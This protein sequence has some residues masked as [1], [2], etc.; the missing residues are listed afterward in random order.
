MITLRLLH[1]EYDMELRYDEEVSACRFTI[2]CIPSQN[3][4][5]RPLER[6]LS[7]Q[8]DTELSFGEDSFHNDKVYGSVAVPHDS[9][10]FQISGIVEIME[11]D[12]EEDVEEHSLGLYRYPH[13]K[14]IPGQKLRAF[15]DSL[16]I[17]GVD[18]EACRKY[19]GA[20]YE[21]FTY[22]TGST[23]V[24]T[25]A[26]AAWEQGTGVCQ[27]YAHILITLL[28]LAGIP[29]R[30]VVGLMEGEGQSH[31]WVEAAC[32]GKWIGIDPT[33]NRLINDSYIRLGCGRDADDC[34]INRGIVLGGGGEHQTIHVVVREHQQ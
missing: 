5:Q 14:C 17:E 10:R 33:H 20:V 12:Y 21:N 19:M 28:K 6:C 18:L 30:Y 22:V 2:K 11:S 1:Y 8:P 16:E 7:V 3:Q 29:A 32:S 13:G 4:R 31:A 9:F 27:D 23:Q 34:A 26:E 25:D 24:F 15:F